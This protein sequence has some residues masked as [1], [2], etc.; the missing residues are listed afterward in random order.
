MRS[1]VRL[2]LAAN[3]PRRGFGWW[4]GSRSLPAR[5]PLRALTCLDLAF[6]AVFAAV[7]VLRIV[8][9]PLIPF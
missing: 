8:V 5:L 6:T 9:V 3:Q 7:I 2:A 1:R 4:L